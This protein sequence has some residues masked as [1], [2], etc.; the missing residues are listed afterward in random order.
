MTSK[1]PIRWAIEPLRRYA[2]FSGRSSRSEF[3]W[4]WLMMV[5]VNI[6]LTRLQSAGLPVVSVLLSLPF[7]IPQ[8]AVCFRRLHDTDRSAWWLLMPVA[9]IVLMFSSSFVLASIAS[10]PGLVGALP[11][12]LSALILLATLVVLLVWFCKAGTVGPNRHGADPLDP[13][14]GIAAVFS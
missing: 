1:T 10:Q 2:K 6:V 14:G 5:V 12:L 9:A 4:F 7:Y 3:W 8:L 13:T 11:I